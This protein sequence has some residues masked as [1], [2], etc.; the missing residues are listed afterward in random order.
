M[1]SSEGH[2]SSVD[3]RFN[4]VLADYWAAVESGEVPDRQRLL[5]EH[6]DLAEQLQE[7]FDNHDAMVGRVAGQSDPSSTLPGEA[8]TMALGATVTSRSGIGRMK[9]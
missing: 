6:P 1:S 3:S 2:S 7:F 5:S 9:R 8:P 4:A